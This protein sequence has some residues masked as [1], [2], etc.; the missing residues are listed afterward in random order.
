M[1][2]WVSAPEYRRQLA[3]GL[4]LQ[5]WLG[6]VLTMLPLWWFQ[7][8]FFALSL[9]VATGCKFIAIWRKQ[10]WL[11]WLGLAA[12][13]PIG[14]LL[15]Y[16]NYRSQS[17]TF[18]F[19]AL[20]ALMGTA[21]MLE[22]RNE[23]DCKI[24]F[25]LELTLMMA[26]LMY[27][28]SI[29][30]FI[31]LLFVLGYI[32]LV[33]MRIAQRGN[34]V[35]LLGR[36]QEIGKLLMLALPFTILLFFFFPRIQPSWGIPRNENQAVTGLPDEMDMG[37]IASLVQSNEPVFRVR[38]ANNELPPPSE[39]YW[40]GTTLWSFDG[41]N[42]RQRNNDMRIQPSNIQYNQES[43]F[44]YD[45]MPV[46]DSLKW[47]PALE[48]SFSFPDAL[49]IG[50]SYQLKLP[51]NHKVPARYH[52]KSAVDYRTVGALD[53]AT[54]A[55][56]LQL[57]DDVAIPQTRALAE[58]LYHES[59]EN[60][61]GFAKAFADYIQDEE[62]YYTLEPP[63]GMGNVEQ[64]LFEGRMGFCEHYASAMTQAARSVGIPARIVIGY[65]GGEHNPLNDDFLV[66]EESAHAWVELWD[67]ARGWFRSDP[68]AAVAP[69]RINQ[70]QLN[71]SSLQRGE[72]QRAFGT[73]LAENMAS[74]A[75]LR[76][77]YGAANA[78]WQDWV[79]DLNRD[80]QG[81][82]LEKLG[83]KGA[84]NKLLIAILLFCTMAGGTLLWL[85]WQRRPR[86]DDDDVAKAVRLLLK[87]L[88][89]SGLRK[90]NR[91]SVADF[92]L[93]IAPYMQKENSAELK[94]ISARYEQARYY[95][96]ENNSQL[97]D[98]IHRF[99]VRH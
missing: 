36:W 32:L 5:V 42:W 81:S 50:G 24:L 48:L 13:L 78:F 47:L 7:P 62:F 90:R 64:F 58:R 59:G 43:E 77:A 66:R 4:W 33:Q 49:Q 93:R 19:L 8:R 95:G 85:W 35:I 29:A 14:L 38:F 63:P 6:F 94:R 20:L 71:A 12:V 23:R 2:K 91:E 1:I 82:L 67:D 41:K 88:E 69:E 34:R 83:L 55:A 68:T 70:A 18:S 22:S 31:Y 17:L 56:A 27:S 99:R 10:S 54:K 21:K 15:I 25:L 44:S 28:Q 60:A 79:I 75:W 92:L 26:F 97:I 16:S 57:P 11:G 74:F 46:K 52:L 86:H 9:I 89:H 51:D 65:Q 45:L 96:N 30:I 73:R 53:D 39:R 72:D 37:D 98:S 87:R 40:R 84:G 80:Q 61:V 3:S 76:N